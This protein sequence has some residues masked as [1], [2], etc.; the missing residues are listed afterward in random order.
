MEGAVV[1][2]D[3][4]EHVQ[5]LDSIRGEMRPAASQRTTTGGASGASHTTSASRARR[6]PPNSSW[7]AWLRSRAHTQSWPSLDT[8][9]A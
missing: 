5:Q 3:G 7:S 6:P 4:E 9:Q 1:K 2:G 8:N